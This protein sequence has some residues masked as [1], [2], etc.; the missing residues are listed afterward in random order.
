MDDPRQ[1]LEVSGILK[2]V[3]CL[4]EFREIGVLQQSSFSAATPLPSPVYSTTLLV[5][6]KASSSISAKHAI[7]C[8]TLWR[9]QVG[10]MKNE[11]E[12]NY[13]QLVG[14]IFSFR[15]GT[16]F[17]NLVHSIS[18]E[19]LAIKRIPIRRL[20]LKEDTNSLTCLD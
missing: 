3:Y 2:C 18:T 4:A 10:Q 13:N 20:F 1:K 9:N 14:K 12:H 5:V 11:K 8:T 17:S 19:S 7:I 16:S 6:R 15:D